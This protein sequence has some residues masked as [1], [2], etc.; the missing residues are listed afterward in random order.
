M[1][2]GIILPILIGIAV[3]GL[4]G[5]SQ[6][7]ETAT[8]TFTTDTTISSDSTEANLF[9]S[10]ETSQ[11]ENHFIGSTVIEVVIV[12]PSIDDINIPRGEPDVTVNG[13]DLRMVQAVDSNWYGYFADREQ[14]QLA[15]ETVEVAG[16][17]GVGER[18]RHADDRWQCLL[19][20]NFGHGRWVYFLKGAGSSTGSSLK[21]SP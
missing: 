10:A 1:S 19:S 3:L 6:E 17:P 15:D 11:Y 4:I 2:R 12:D 21:C 14:A 5:F 20:P 18:G 16:V 7:A 13:K 8:M 9:V